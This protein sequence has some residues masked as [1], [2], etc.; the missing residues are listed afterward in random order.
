LPTRLPHT[1]T[2][3]EI[4]HQIA[5]VRPMLAMRSARS[6][7][8]TTKGAITAKIIPTTAMITKRRTTPGASTP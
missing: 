8:S 4:E 2:V 1:I 3:A 7:L 6:R 5:V